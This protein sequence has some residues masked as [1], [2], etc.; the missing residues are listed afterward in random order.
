MEQW[1]HANQL[2]ANECIPEPNESLPSGS[3]LCRKDW[4]ALNRARSGVGRTGD[5]LVQWKLKDDAACPCGEEL[6][7]MDHIL[8]ECTL[9]PSCSNQ[10]LLEANQAAVQWIQWW[11]DTI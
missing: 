6:Q 11:R 7:T 10:D 2:L 8:R 1:K 9:G 5:N 4:V 3:T